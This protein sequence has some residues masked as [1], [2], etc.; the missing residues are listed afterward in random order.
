M[1][2]PSFKGHLKL[3]ILKMLTEKPMHGYGVMAELEKT[4]GIPH[5]SPGTV[6]PILASLK[7]A[8]L[9]ET[10]GK[11][12]REKR[13]YRATE[14]GAQYLREHEDELREIEE[15]A[16]RFREFARLGGRELGIVLKEVFN[17][18][19][20]LT[21]EQKRALAKE[22]SEFIKRVRLILLGEVEGP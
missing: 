16:E 10:V 1:E 14:K 8:G 4:Y 19:D 2:R 20:D 7:R 6:Y 5:P 17:S 21:N 3:L 9:I 13:L 22:F 11:G 18:L 15:L 12:K